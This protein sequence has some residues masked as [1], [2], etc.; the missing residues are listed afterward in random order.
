MMAE[1][2]E[3]APA[4]LRQRLGAGAR[5]DSEAAP[6]AQLLMMRLARSAC[7]R[8]LSRI[9]DNDLERAPLALSLAKLGCVA[10]LIAEAFEAS[11]DHQGIEGDHAERSTNLDAEITRAKTLPGRALR[12]LYLHALQH[13]DVACRHLDATGWGAPLSVPEPGATTP[14]LAIDHMAD[15]LG[16]AAATFAAFA[17]RGRLP[18]PKP[19]STESG[20]PS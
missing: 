6:S 7:Q 19:Q 14:D 12:S 5:Y 20:V 17:D 18:L 9:G 13:L 11:A 1:T 2:L 15:L 8:Q 4:R 10:R 3:A 16:R